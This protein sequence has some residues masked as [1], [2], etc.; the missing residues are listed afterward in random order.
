MS[1]AVS[2][3]SRFLEDRLGTTEATAMEMTFCRA[4]FS[5]G[6]TW[7]IT[8]RACRF[9][10]LLESCSRGRNLSKICTH[11]RFTCDFFF[12]FFFLLAGCLT[13]KQHAD[14][15]QGW[16]SSEKFMCCHTEIGS[17]DHKVNI[18]RG[19]KTVVLLECLWLL[20]F[21]CCLSLVLVSAKGIEDRTC[22]LPDQH[23]QSDDHQVDMVQDARRQKSNACWDWSFQSKHSLQPSLKNGIHP[24]LLLMCTEHIDNVPFP[25]A[26]VYRTHRQCTLSCC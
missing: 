15:S 21:Y 6:T 1:A 12:F 22:N 2:L 10:L 8:F 23:R 26:N 3:I 11:R 17:S 24:F 16:T 7:C 9:T 25:A 19:P 20:R 4:S 18:L 5:M 14:V 13:S